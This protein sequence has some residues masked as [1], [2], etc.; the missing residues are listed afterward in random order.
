MEIFRKAMGK[1][2][3]LPKAKLYPCL[4]E[5]CDKQIAKLSTRVTMLANP[6][7]AYRADAQ[8]KG[9][10]GGGSGS[11]GSGSGA[12]NGGGWKNK[13]WQGAHTANQDGSG[14]GAVRKGGDGTA[15][16]NT[17]SKICA[18]CSGFHPF[19]FYCE[20]FIKAKVKD[21]F[22]MVLK[23]KSCS[24][25]LTLGRSFDGKRDIWWPDHELYCKNTF[26]CEEGTCQNAPK[27]KQRHLVMCT[28]HY[29]Q[30]TALIP[31]FVKK[32]HAKE[33]PKGCSPQNLRYFHVQTYYSVG[34]TV[35]VLPLTKDHLGYKLLPDVPEESIFMLQTI[36]SEDPSCPLLVFYDS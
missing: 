5:L 3:S 16:K 36:P 21:R 8:G 29:K 4:L 15:P 18:F 20:H 9:G 14:G 13:G 35:P 6:D 24:R 10:N 30:N 25:C 34:G 11:G 28:A 12:A 7:T 26:I 23:Q 32:L 2:K 27:D 1:L 17:S 33:L 22:T 19:M 31:D